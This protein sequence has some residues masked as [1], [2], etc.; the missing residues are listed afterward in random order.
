MVVVP[1]KK[2]ELENTFV[3]EGSS[4]NLD[5]LEMLAD[6]IFIELHFVS[7]HDR[8]EPWFQIEANLFAGSKSTEREYQMILTERGHD[9]LEHVLLNSSHLPEC[10][11]IS[12]PTLAEM[13]A[14][15]NAAKLDL[16]LTSTVA[17]AFRE[18]F[19]LDVTLRYEDAG[20]I[21]AYFCVFS[22]ADDHEPIMTWL[23]EI[24]GWDSKTDPALRPEMRA[25]KHA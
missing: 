24:Q 8:G 25:Q 11:L 23:F 12:L 4:I 22:E 16:W 14:E 19:K 7:A 9:G 5:R 2:P 18:G 15:G 6:S 17:V 1:F 20:F 21:N 3:I 13:I 10:T